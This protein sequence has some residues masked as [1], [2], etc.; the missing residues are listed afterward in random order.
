M[1]ELAYLNG[2]FMPIK[3]AFVPIEDRGYQF[4]DA[5]YEG[6]ASY[7]G[8]LFH[9][10]A[11]LDRLDRSMKE[12]DFPA[13]SRDEIRAAI[14]ELFRRSTFARAFIYLQISRS[15][16][17]RNHAFPHSPTPQVV[18]T[19]REVSEVPAIDRE[20][21]ISLITVK[22]LRWG[23]CDIKTV[24]LLA[25]SMAKQKALDAGA[26]D[27]LFVSTEGIVREATSSNLF[28][29]NSGTVVTH[30]RTENILPGITRAVVLDVSRQLNVPVEERFFTTAELFAADEAFLT[31]TTTEVLPIIKI[32]DKTIG[33]GKPGPIS[34][35]L[36][37]GLK[38]A[39]RSVD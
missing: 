33:N 8:R 29:V 27:A 34:M 14:E 4:G 35:R 30:P 24:Q 13:V 3:E 10:E 23:R 31:G 6:I 28:V 17:P 22:D 18:M 9:L 5:V 7:D 39:A 16:A 11:H 38:A 26:Y 25:N 2:V 36:E 15:V 1:P 21:G 37:D 32:D 19:I 12:L 20:Q